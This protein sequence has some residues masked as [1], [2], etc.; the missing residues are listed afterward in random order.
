MLVIRRFDFSTRTAL[1]AGWL[2]GRSGSIAWSNCADPP[3]PGTDAFS[4]S[5]EGHFFGGG[6]ISSVTCTAECGQKQ[7]FRFYKICVGGAWGLSGG[8]GLVGNMNGTSCRSDTYKGYFYE[9]G[10]SY[11]VCGG[12]ISFGYYG[13]FP[14]LPTSPNG[15]TEWSGGIGLPRGASVKSTWCWYIPLP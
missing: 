8:G 10:G 14:E 6:G 15:V 4:F 12:G 1:Y 2:R 9:A 3:P 7:T 5:M 11:G 13:S